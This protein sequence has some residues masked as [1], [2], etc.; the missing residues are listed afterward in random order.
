MNKSKIRIALLTS[1]LLFGAAASLTGCKMTLGGPLQS[2][3]R[4][5]VSIAVVEGSVPAIVYVNEFDAAGIKIAVKYSDGN[6]DE[7][8]LTSAMIP[9]E[10][11][12]Y[13][14]QPGDVDVTFLFR[15]QE[16]VLKLKIAFH[17][18]L[19]QFL[20]LT[21]S[22]TPE[23]IAT[24]SVKKGEGATAPECVKS[25]AYDHSL[26]T[27]TSW[28]TDF[29][30]IQADLQVNA[31]YSE[32]AICWVSFYNGANE[33]IKKEFVKTGENAVA[34]SAEEIA[35]PGY[36]F[37]GWDRAFNAVNADCD[38][39]G[40]YFKIENAATLLQWDG[41]IA[42]SYGGGQGTSADPYV[43]ATP[44]QL[45]YLQ[46]QSALSSLESLYFVQSIDFNLSG[47]PWTP[48]GFSKESSSFAHVFGGHYDGKGHL[49]KGMTIQG[50]T[51][52]RGLGFA[53][54]SSGTI[55]RLG[56]ENFT[57]EGTTNTWGAGFGAFVGTIS[58]GSLTD[59]YAKN[60]SIKIDLSD[61]S[62]ASDVGGLIGKSAGSATMSHCFSLQN[63]L[64]MNYGSA[65]GILGIAQSD[66]TVSSCFV[67][68]LTISAAQAHNVA[69]AVGG[70]EGA[71]STKISD[72]KVAS[73][74]SSNQSGSS[75]GTD[76]VKISFAE[77]DAAS[78]YSDF[79]SNWSFANLDYANQ[80][81][82]QLIPE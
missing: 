1:F 59:C 23:I 32:E 21:T 63:T 2:E 39:Y 51:T 12:A 18:Y 66:F 25:L 38:V 72:V 44:A 30:N 7:I 53:G 26:Y 10:Y 58:G 77:L 65:G 6:T 79:S 29:S 31:L 33:L 82:P 19:V 78:L 74:C 15:G 81:Y 57:I 67:A 54:A 13:L 28:N 36:D 14:S 45:A 60:G 8:P 68:G 64:T 37:L 3:D 41:S 70:N 80:V 24:E 73:D 76:G 5:I 49:I 50:L 27:F 52:S 40:I 75:S 48:L 61:S 16:I 46:A 69:L 34:P 62:Q 9:E 11:R 35:M 47:Y 55:S 4:N 71:T 56:L 20:A 17:Y 22:S 42:A 43:I